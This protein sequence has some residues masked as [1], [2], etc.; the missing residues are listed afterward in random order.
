[1]NLLTLFTRNDVAARLIRHTIGSSGIMVLNRVILLALGILLARYLGTEGYGVYALA[2]A[3][4]EILLI[5]SNAGTGPLLV[6]EISISWGKEDWPDLKGKLIWGIKYTTLTSLSISII[7]IIILFDQFYNIDNS[8]FLTYLLMLALIPVAT[9]ANTLNSILRGLHQI[10]ISLAVF[11]LTKSILYVAF[12]I[13]FFTY[14]EEYRNP[15]YAMTAQL[16]A[17]III[18]VIS[19]VF[20]HRKTPVEMYSKQSHINK[21]KLARNA[22]PFM[23]MGGAT[24]INYNADIIM[25]GWIVSAEESG[26]YKVAVHGSTLVILSLEIIG[27]VIAPQIA[28]LYSQGKKEQLQKILTISTRAVAAISIPSAMIF[29]VFGDF[30]LGSIF[31]Q[32]F[33]KG[34]SALAILSIGQAVNAL[35]GMASVL[36]NMTGYEKYTTMALWKSTVTN[37]ALNLLLIPYFGINGAACAAA[38]SLIIFNLILVKEAKNKTG[39]S[40]SIFTKT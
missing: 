17:V 22:L 27:T 12:I 8:T 34:H 19:A 13:S 11:R 6:R 1:M 35:L 23:L 32:S 36:L 3:T 28:Q 4:M 38:I 9:L 5:F 33:S 2:I 15:E 7:G 39:V 24:I 40:T 37:I 18:L 30:I 16:I 31:G 14:S 20:L 21:H 10:I 29:I 26:I 25:L